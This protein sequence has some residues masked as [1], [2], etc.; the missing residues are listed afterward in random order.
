MEVSYTRYDF[1]IFGV[2]SLQNY[3]GFNQNLAKRSSVTTGIVI[4]PEL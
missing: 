4:K 3:I 2:R 1:N